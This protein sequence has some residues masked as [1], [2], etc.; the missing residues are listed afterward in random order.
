[1][2]R[3]KEK[4]GYNYCSKIEK[5]QYFISKLVTAGIVA[6]IINLIPNII[7]IIMTSIFL[8]GKNGFMDVENGL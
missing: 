8:H 3:K 6:V 1:M 4:Y 7:S 2:S 5:K